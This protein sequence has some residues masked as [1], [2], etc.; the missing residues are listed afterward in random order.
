MSDIRPVPQ[1]PPERRELELPA[2]DDPRRQVIVVEGGTRRRDPLDTTLRLLT[3]LTLA[4]VVLLLGAMLLL[5]ASLA[6]TVSSAGTGI[7]QAGEQLLGEAQRTAQR[8][9]DLA[10]PAHPPRGVLSHD[11]EFDELRT[12]PI[13]GSL[14]ALEQYTLTLSDIR[15]RNGASDRDE[16]QYAVLQRR[17]KEPRRTTLGPL[18]VR[19]DWGEAELYL[20]KGETIR[21]GQTYYRVNWVSV[22]QRGMAISRYRSPDELT[23]APKYQLQ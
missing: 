21:L 15:K 11:T 5:V 22:E 19:E 2:W 12:V 6:G 4:M 7:G 18:V 9:A 3:A 14:G 17:L 13:D 8:L 1:G 23:V 20:Y 16:A 10:D